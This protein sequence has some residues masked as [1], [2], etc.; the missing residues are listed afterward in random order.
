MTHSIYR[1]RLEVTDSQ[2]V[3]MPKGADI[4]SVQRREGSQTVVAAGTHESIDMWALVDLAAPM[5]K[6]RFRVAGTG[7]PL[8]AANNLT[9]LGTVQIARGRLV[10]HVFEVH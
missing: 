3:E 5:E 8:T 7:H 1:Y 9:F 6:R 2:L 10:F 4:L